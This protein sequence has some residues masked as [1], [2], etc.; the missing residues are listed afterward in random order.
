M[1]V[2]ENNKCVGCM[3]CL[4]VCN[5]DA[6]R[7]VDSLKFYRAEIDE[8]KCV[9]CGQCKKV[10]QN[11]SAVELKRPEKWYQGWANDAQVRAN[12]S[13]GGLASAIEIGFIRNGGA[14]CSCLLKDGIFQF[15]I[16]TSIEA[17]KGFAGSKYVKSNPTGIYQEVDALLRKGKKVLFLGLPCQAEAM[18]RYTGNHE[19]LYTVDLICHGTPSPQL[20]NDYLK[21]YGYKAD[22]LEQITFRKKD[23]FR[24]A[25]N[26][27]T[28][29]YPGTVDRYSL[30]FLCSIDYTENCY[31]CR[32]AGIERG[33]SLT[34]GDSWGSDLNRKEQ[35]KG[36]SLILCQDAKGQQ[37]L[38]LADITL[39]PVDLARAISCNHQLRE[40]CHRTE[41]TDKFFDSYSG[42]F[43]SKVFAC[44]P[45]KC[46]KQFIKGILLMLKVIRGG[47]IEYGVTLRIKQKKKNIEG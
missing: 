30:A 2:C 14:V 4:S 46:F 41:K 6:I 9:N 24:V 36:I 34:L 7:I 11:N 47:A 22:E 37:L 45:Q 31:S 25:P 3:V 33:S 12:A 42:N 44:L 1:T 19:L 21:K 13:S 32:F 10:C 15:E 18:R 29:T 5:K 27:V 23:Y 17:L 38:E 16:A 35:K 39:H 28:T 26:E 40:P 43:Y 8:N 20:L